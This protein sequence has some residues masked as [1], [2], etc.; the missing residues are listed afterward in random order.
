M[1]MFLAMGDTTEQTTQERIAYQ[2]RIVF[3]T[4]GIIK[5]RDW[6]KLSDEIKLDRLTKMQE[7]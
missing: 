4:P 5:P 6:D 7:I 3:A 1:K 2:E